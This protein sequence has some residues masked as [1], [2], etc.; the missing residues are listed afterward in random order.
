[1]P[2][3]SDT[4][5]VD[6][7]AWFLRDEATA[8]AHGSLPALVSTAM[9]A[10][11]GI[12]L[13]WNTSLLLPGIVLSPVT[14]LAGP[15]TS[16]TLLLTLGFAGSATS[17]FLVLRQWGASLV[18]AALGGAM[19]GF[20]P[21]LLDA[22][23]GHYHIQ[24]AVLPPLIIHMLLR[25]VTGRGRPVRNGVWLGVLAAAQLFTGEELLVDTIVAAVVIVV[26]VAAGHLRAVRVQVKGTFI[27]LATAA[28]VALVLCGYALWEQLRGPL[29]QHGSPWPTSAFYA[30]PAVLI[31]PPLSLLFHTSASA[32]TAA[33][34]YAT[35]LAEYL[36]YVGLPLF[37][38]LVA[39]AI[40]YWRDPKIR[41]V[42]V[43]CAVL[44]IFTLG[45]NAAYLPWHYLQQLPVLGQ[46]LPGRLAVPADAAAAAVLAF[47]FDRVRASAPR[48]SDWR[49]R[50][51]TG[52]AVLALLPLVPLPYRADKITPVPAGWQTAF[53]RLHLAADAPVLVVPVPYQ[54]NTDALRW[55]AQTRAPGSLIEGYFIGPNRSG[56]AE[57][58]GIG[59]PNTAR[60]MDEIWAGERKPAPSPVR[61]R[62]TFAAWRPAAVVAVASPGSRIGRILIGILGPPDFRAGRVMAWRR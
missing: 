29:R 16:L 37:V 15:Q 10:P 21:A 58:Y 11:H 2:S 8:L 43:T 52:V 47:S 22:G 49:A 34:N 24:F 7:F 38:V 3:F 6:L 50:L 26:V 33:H 54:K 18:A 20:S 60:T 62:A 56:H 19:Y 55:Q 17:L 32:A 40:V 36:G 30:R 28:V 13:L 61:L 59:L 25:L 12:S 14:L 45:G 23:L 1:F 44:E 53:G 48:L 9:N 42:A 51:A 57:E 5:D 39:A 35:S 27:G 46:L 4:R 41:A 31:T